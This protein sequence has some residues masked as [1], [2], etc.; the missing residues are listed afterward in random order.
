M[1]IVDRIK[2]GIAHFV[3]LGFS[4]KNVEYGSFEHPKC[5]FKLMDKNII[6]I[7]L[8]NFFAEQAFW[9]YLLAKNNK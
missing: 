2:Y 3:I 5:M 9:P 8:L 7:L 6:A 1:F 4:G